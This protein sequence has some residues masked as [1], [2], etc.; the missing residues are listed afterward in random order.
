MLPGETSGERDAFIIAQRKLSRRTIA[1]IFAV[2]A[3]RLSGEGEPPEPRIYIERLSSQEVEA[4][5]DYLKG[6]SLRV[7]ELYPG[8]AQVIETIVDDICSVVGEVHFNRVIY[9]VP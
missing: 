7:P 8:I 9:G 2:C 5:Y 4:I 3:Y 1:W 6:F